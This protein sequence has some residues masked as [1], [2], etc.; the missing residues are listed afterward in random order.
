MS[1]DMSL[2]PPEL[3]IGAVPVVEAEADYFKLRR[4]SYFIFSSYYAK[5]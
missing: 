1:Q 5:S 3:G 2:L 4:H